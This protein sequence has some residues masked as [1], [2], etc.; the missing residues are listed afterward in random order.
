MELPFIFDTFLVGLSADSP[1][2][3]LPVAEIEAHTSS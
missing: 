2:M 3:Q 1:F